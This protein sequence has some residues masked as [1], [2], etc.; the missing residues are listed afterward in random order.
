MVDLSVNLAGLTLD[1]PVIA[2]S[3]TYGYGEEFI[4]FYDLDILGSISFKGTTL[5]ARKGNALARIAECPSGM[6]NSVGLQNPGVDHVIEHELK[7]M[8]EIYHKPVIANICG[9]SIEEYGLLAERFNECDQV[10]IIEVNISC[11]NVHEGGMTFG[12]DAKTAAEVT[13]IVKKATSKPV[14][15]KLTPNVTDIVQIAKAC[16]GAGCD[17]LSLINTVLG[18]RIDLRS[19]KPVLN[20]IFGGLSGPA[21]FPIALRMTY[22]VAGAVN[23]PI[24]G[25][26]GV[27]TAKDVIEM[28]LAGATAVQVGTANLVNPMAC[29]DIIRDLPSVA[30]EYGIEKLSSITGGAIA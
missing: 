16:E 21:V 30:E 10:G 28:M 5:K 15:V 13:R 12:S 1:N 3:G 4:G 6:L 7:R 20:N 27:S 2:A 8:S 19:R 11:P 18:M 25:M 26:G 24:I 14:F 22:Q 9:F 17:G 29:A 23:V